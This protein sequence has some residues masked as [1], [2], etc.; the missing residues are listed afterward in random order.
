MPIG[1]HGLPAWMQFKRHLATLPTYSTAS[2]TLYGRR[3]PKPPPQLEGTT[4]E[5]LLCWGTAGSMPS[6]EQMPT[7]GFTVKYPEDWGEQTRATRDIRIQNPD[8]PE[9]YVVDRR[10]ATIDFIKTAKEGKAGS[11]TAA[12]EAPGIADYENTDK[13]IATDSSGGSVTKTKVRMHY[14]TG[15]APTETV[16]AS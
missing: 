6:P 14:S 16:V 13:F 11:N 8:D 4:P 15:L 10:P 1:A 9:Q 12:E 5:G 3:I 2:T 7:V